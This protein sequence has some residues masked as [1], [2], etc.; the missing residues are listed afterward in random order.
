ME[1]LTD[2]WPSISVS[3]CPGCGLLHKTSRMAPDALAELYEGSWR[4]P[5]QNTE[6]TGGTD[7]RLARMLAMRLLESLNRKDFGGLKLLDFGAGRGEFLRVLQNLGADVYGVD[8]FGCDYLQ[9]LGFKAFPDLQALPADLQL[10]GAVTVDVIEHLHRPWEHLKLLRERLAPQGW[11]FAATPNAGSAAARV[12]GP[13]WKEAGK[14][15][16][17][18]FFTPNSLERILDWSGYGQLRR[19]RWR[20]EYTSGSPKKQI[21][22]ALQ[23]LGWDGQLKYLALRK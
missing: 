19:L 15:G 16:H 23:I 18:L 20:I 3:R 22:T 8:P 21:Q 14:P 13:K 9:G 7:A 12:S 17:L 10:D 4:T 2:M 5:D 6:E 11:L 1:T